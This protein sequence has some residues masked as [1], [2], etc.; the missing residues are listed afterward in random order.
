MIGGRWLRIERNCQM[1]Y[2]KRTTVGKGSG[3]KKI[4]GWLT[5]SMR[6][7]GDGRC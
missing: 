5:R 6:K 1:R 4:G 3:A 2:L 7:Q